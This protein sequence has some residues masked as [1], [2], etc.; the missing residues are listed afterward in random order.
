MNDGIKF[1]EL[2]DYTEAENKRWKQLFARHPEALALPLN[3]AGNVQQLVLHIFAVELYFANA[4]SGHKVD[5][6][7]LPTNTLDETF[8]IG[9]QAARIYREFF[10]RAKPEDWSGLVDL[11]RIG[12]RASKRKLVAQAFTHS[13][14]HWAQVALSSAS[15]D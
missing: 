10:A 1:S 6:D 8:A 14:R 13:I 3:I 9:E 7:S 12:L 4:I 11:G 15:M 2:L 5:P